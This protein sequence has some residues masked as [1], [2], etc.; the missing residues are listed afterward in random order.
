MKKMPAQAKQPPF[1]SIDWT[2]NLLFCS[3]GS[4]PQVG[5]DKN[6]AG[7]RNAPRAVIPAQR[8]VVMGVV[9]MI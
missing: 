7:K 2:K 6:L 9:A 3:D 5:N 4:V 8:P 1:L